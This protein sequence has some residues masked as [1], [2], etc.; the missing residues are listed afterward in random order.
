MAF[1]PLFSLVLLTT[2]TAQEPVRA[3]RLVVKSLEPKV[4]NS[5]ANR[6]P[7]TQIGSLHSK[8]FDVFV[9]G[10]WSLLIGYLIIIYL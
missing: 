7:D 8:S 2:V 3:I 4:E 1:T 6:L 10:S 5:L 9:C